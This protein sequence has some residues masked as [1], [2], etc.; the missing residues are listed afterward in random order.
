MVW[1]RLAPCRIDSLGELFLYSYVV[2][3]WFQTK[4]WLWM[5]ELGLQDDYSWISIKQEE[6]AIEKARRSYGGVV[7]RLLDIVRGSLVVDNL[8]QVEQLLEIVA[9]DTDVEIVRGKNRFSSDMKD[10]YRDVQLTVRCKA[11]SFDAL[12]GYDAARTPLIKAHTC[13]KLC[14]EVQIHLRSFYDFKNEQ[15]HTDYKKYRAIM[16]E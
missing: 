14:A 5:K 6:R 9:A 10:L 13:K 11:F 8:A 2:N 16:G 1:C 12:P 4:C 15:S 7:Q 3:T